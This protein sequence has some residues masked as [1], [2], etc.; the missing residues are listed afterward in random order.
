MR[1]HAALCRFRDKS[2]YVMLLL[3][4]VLLLG[5]RRAD[6]LR[7]AS[8]LQESGG[9]EVPKDGSM[10]WREYT[11]TPGLMTGVCWCRCVSVCVPMCIICTLS[12][13]QFTLK[14]F[15]RG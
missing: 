7:E 3:P 1:P 11:F 14:L 12:C 6:A 10:P 8:A 2:A 15:L 4:L 9:A 5:L 13:F